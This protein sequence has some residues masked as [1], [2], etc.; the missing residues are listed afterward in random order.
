ML[1]AQSLLKQYAEDE[2]KDFRGFSKDVEKVFM[3]YDW[4]GNVRELSNV[5]RN[6]VVLNEGRVIDISMLPNLIQSQ[7]SKSSRAWA[8]GNN[9]PGFG[10]VA[11]VPRTEGGLGEIADAVQSDS[12]NQEILPFWVEER[13]IIE[14]AIEKCDG[15][16]PRA[17]VLLELG[18][19]TIYRKKQQWDKAQIARESI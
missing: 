17:A 11:P 9:P 4:P 8:L 7:K 1:I 19:S 5:V 16:V 15:N 14:S 18:V 6:M 10:E 12:G 3:Q 13:R 2:K